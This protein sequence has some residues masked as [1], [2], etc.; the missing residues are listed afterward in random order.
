MQHQSYEN[1][2]KITVICIGLLSTV[3][4][5]Y[6]N[7]SD[8]YK[9]F[10]INKYYPFEILLP[11]IGTHAIIDFFITCK[12]DIKFHHLCVFG[13][14]FYNYYYRVA[15]EIQI[16][17]TYPLIKTEISSIFLALKEYIP[18]NSVWYTI[19]SVLF[20]TCF[21]KLRILDFY[22]EIIHNHDSLNFVIW[23]YSSENHLLNV[24]L[25]S[26]CYGLYILN[27]YWFYIINKI[28]YKGLTKIFSGM[29][30]DQTGRWLCPYIHILNIPLTV[31]I[32]Y[33]QPNEKYLFYMIGVTAL[34][35]TSFLYQYDLFH[36]R[37]RQ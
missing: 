14:L 12:L 33:Q 20:Y 25:F 5:W 32:Y 7:Q 16:Y 34:C 2:L 27:I 22:N 3:A 15:D 26:S 18:K 23:A 24:I 19:N 35:G 37:E 9:Y 6:Y 21:F 28:L 13:V 31:C 17:L 10:N 4:C 30:I 29:N 36:A 11:V 8:T 1:F